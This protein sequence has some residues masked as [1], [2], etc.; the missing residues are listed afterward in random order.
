MHVNEN[1]RVVIQ[2]ITGNQGIFHAKLMRAYGTK[3]V[4]GVT[5][6]KGGQ[7]VQGIPVF[8]TMKEA[9]SETCCDTSIIFVP[10]RFTFNAVE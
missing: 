9:V 6:K 3:I 7:D 1:S 5:P 2:G 8:N 10:A 4:A